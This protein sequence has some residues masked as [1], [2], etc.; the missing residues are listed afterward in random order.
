MARGYRLRLLQPPVQESAPHGDE[1]RHPTTLALHKETQYPS[2]SLEDEESD[3]EEGPSVVDIG[4]FCPRGWA[5]SGD[6]VISGQPLSARSR[7]FSTKG[8]KKHTIITSNPMEDVWLESEYD[9]QANEENRIN[10]R[11]DS[12]NDGP[13]R[14]RV[15]P[16]DGQ[17]SSSRSSERMNFGSTL[18]GTSEYKVMKDTRN[19]ELCKQAMRNRTAQAVSDLPST[20]GAISRPRRGS[21]FETS[22]CD[23]VI[24]REPRRSPLRVNSE[25]DLHKAT[26]LIKDNLANIIENYILKPKLQEKLYKPI[27]SSESQI[28]SPIAVGYRTDV[29]PETLELSLNPTQQNSD[30]EISL[31]LGAEA[32]T[33]SPI[34]VNVVDHEKILESTSKYRGARKDSSDSDVRTSSQLT[35]ASEELEKEESVID[36]LGAI[37][38]L[39]ESINS[40][41][42]T[43]EKITKIGVSEDPFVITSS[44]SSASENVNAFVETSAVKKSVNNLE[45]VEDTSIIDKSDEKLDNQNEPKNVDEVLSEVSKELAKCNEPSIKHTEPQSYNESNK[46][47]RCYI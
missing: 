19:Y 39:S 15:E 1:P 44:E 18:P 7:L 33:P 14:V 9:G 10:E 25:A 45:N 37:S 41:S 26:S 30:S 20:S 16:N 8:G 43:V 6:R 11:I 42:S 40:N 36:T 32:L 47:I 23:D 5:V 3:F 28:S 27:N 24:T 38:S 4:R 46:F 13:D 17:A 29:T 12:G 35:T 34:S 2:Q 21:F 31:K 22:E